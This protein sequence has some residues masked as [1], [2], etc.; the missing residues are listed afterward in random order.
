MKRYIFVLGLFIAT[1][2]LSA[3]ESNLFSRLYHKINRQVAAHKKLPWV[4]LVERE[5]QQALPQSIWGMKDHF[6]PVQVQPAPGAHQKLLFEMRVKRWQKLI[7]RHPVLANFTLK[8]PQVQDV[9]DMSAQQISFLT[10]FLQ[11]GVTRGTANSTYVPARVE[12][13]KH[14]LVRLRLQ[15]STGERPIYLTANC[16]TRELFLSLRPTL[17]NI[18]LEQPQDQPAFNLH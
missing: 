12:N 3:H 6:I 13:F 17:P 8:V 7:S 10:N 15:P 5:I 18:V 16:Y 4:V 11:N 2:P 1:L 14:Y 9:L